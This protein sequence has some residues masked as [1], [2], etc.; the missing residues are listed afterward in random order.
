MSMPGNPKTLEFLECYAEP[1]DQYTSTA[2]VLSWLARSP[3]DSRAVL[4][5][6]ALNRPDFLEGIVECVKDTRKQINNTLK[7]IRMIQEVAE[8]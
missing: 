8:M 5:D 2:N 3:E 7:A 6:L 4:L 1:D